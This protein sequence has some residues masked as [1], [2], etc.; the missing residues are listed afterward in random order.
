MVCEHFAKI[1][2]KWIVSEH[3]SNNENKW[4]VVAVAYEFSRE[5]W[6]AIKKINNKKELVTK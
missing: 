2:K 5:E 1:S 3:F 4:I 6:I